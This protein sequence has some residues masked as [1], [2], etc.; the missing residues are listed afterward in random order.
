MAGNEAQFYYT[1]IYNEIVTIFRGKCSIWENPFEN[2]EEKKTDSN[3]CFP[4]TK[5]TSILSESVEC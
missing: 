4:E 1:G 3:F 5:F 2:S